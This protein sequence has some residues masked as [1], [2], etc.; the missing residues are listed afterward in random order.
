MEERRCSVAGCGREY[1]CKGFCKFHYQRNTTGV[2]LD[3]PVRKTVRSETQEQWLADHI[4]NPDHGDA[5]IEWPFKK[6]DAGYGI[7]VRGARRFRVHILVMS[8]VEPKPSKKHVVAHMP[9]ECH[10]PPCVSR[11]H[12]RWSTRSGNSQDQKLDGTDNQGENHNMVKLQAV[13][14]LEIRRLHAAGFSLGELATRFNVTKSNVC[15][16]VK[17]RSWKHI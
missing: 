5:C 14:V 12:L 9:V 17:R 6:N 10:N 13:D 1:L 11:N 8:S 16:I 2:P 15:V 3:A 7:L 4:A